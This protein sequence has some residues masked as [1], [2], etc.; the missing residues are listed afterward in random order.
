[1]VLS[2]R[3]TE[4]RNQHRWFAVMFA[5]VGCTANVMKS[6]LFVTLVSLIAFGMDVECDILCSLKEWYGWSGVYI[7]KLVVCDYNFFTYK[8]YE[9]TSFCI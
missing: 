7:N 1:M 9:W 5:S 2:C 8:Q 4:I 6:G 3:F